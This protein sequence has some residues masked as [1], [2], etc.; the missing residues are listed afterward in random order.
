MRA[1]TDSTD[2]PLSKKDA[3][4]TLR[5]I[6]RATKGGWGW[7]PVKREAIRSRVEA[8][9]NS[10]EDVELALDASK[11]LV[12]MDRADIAALSAASQAERPQQGASVQVNVGV[13]IGEA[14]KGVET[15]E[16]YLSASKPL[17]IV[18][19]STNSPID[20]DAVRPV[21]GNHPPS[22]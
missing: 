18:D 15:A 1:V 7:D 11:T 14:S 21:S 8:I 13:Q 19:G 20:G 22:V 2:T 10:S 9:A 6:R 5:L 16:R 3:K 4:A 12:A 17:Q